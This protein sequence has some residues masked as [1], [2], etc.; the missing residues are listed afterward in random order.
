MAAKSATEL[1]ELFSKRFSVGDI[2]GL[3][4]LYED[5]AIFPNHH[6]I[7]KGVERIRPVLQG[8]IDSGATLEFGRQVAF[9]IGDIAL[10]QN[11]WVLTT[12]SCEQVPV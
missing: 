3:M 6:T 9:E 8:Y 10:V 4:Q 12:T 1:I 2:D 11:A 7:A 5:D